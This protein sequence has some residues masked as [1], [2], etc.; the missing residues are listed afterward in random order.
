MSLD[1]IPHPGVDAVPELGVEVAV[2]GGHFQVELLHEPFEL[3]VEEPVE[4]V[5]VETGGQKT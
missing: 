4:P 5:G 3:P 1:V 2:G